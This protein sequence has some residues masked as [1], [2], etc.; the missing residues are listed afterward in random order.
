MEQYR[1]SSFFNVKVKIRFI[2][3]V[4]QAV[5]TGFCFYGFYFLFKAGGFA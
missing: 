4:A 1:L 2:K 5:K 3:K